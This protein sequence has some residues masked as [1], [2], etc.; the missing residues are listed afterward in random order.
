MRK[1]RENAGLLFIIAALSFLILC[2]LIMIFV[3]AVI[4][5]NRLDFSFMISTIMNGANLETIGNTLL[6]G[7]CVVI[8]ATIIAFPLAFIAARTTLGRQKWLDIV[9][10]I[11]FMTPPYIASM[12]WILF[13][14]KRGLFQQLFPGT[15]AWS[16]GFLSFAGLV[17]VMSLHVFPFMYT[18]LKNAILG[19]GASLEESAAVFGGNRI[20]RMFRVTLPLLRG[21]YA[22]G[23]LLVF[24]KTLSEYGTPATIGRRI[25][26]Y[27]FTTDIHR[28]A[29]TSPVNFGAAASLS[30]VLIG[31]CL[32]MWCLQNFITSR[33]TY[34]LVS[35][36]GSRPMVKE[37]SG[38]SAVGAWGFVSLIIAVA[39]GIP[40]FS[41]ISTSLIKLRG[42]GLAP[43]NFTLDHYI[44]LFIENTKGQRALLVSFGLAIASATIAAFIGTAIAT[45]IHQSKQKYRKVVEAL[46]LL[47][48]MLPGIVLVIGIMLFWNTIY[49]VIP[50]YNTIGI[51]VL[52]YVVLFLPFTVQ[53]VTSSFTQIGDNLLAA[54]RTF[55]GN[56]LYNFRRI[57][58]PLLAKGIIAGWIMTFIISFRELVTA[59]LIAPPNTLVVSTF[60]MREF[61]Q[62]SVSVGMAMAVLCVIFTVTVLILLNYFVDK[63]AVKAS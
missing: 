51:M 17:L 61:E 14:Q 25:G 41:V 29:T 6:L 15:G 5:D 63:K 16:E 4:I 39:I 38:L 49:Q 31:I 59:S 58:L 2:P 40:Y 56:P 52:A 30:S 54:G 11:P 62:G 50:L 22:I 60:I 57:T 23:A 1:I 48:E 18:I 37:L 33:T 10:M 27:V 21:N 19:I 32:M 7:I 43:G 3:K 9:L 42:Y 55:G 46:S 35:G 36:K 20:Y 47:P 53:Y 12:G 8:G 34:R 13:M 26:F 28:Y 45:V 24:V 44:A